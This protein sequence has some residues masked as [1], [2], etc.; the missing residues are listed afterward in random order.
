MRELQKG[1]VTYLVEGHHLSSIHLFRLVQRYKIDLFWGQSF[2]GKGALD[3]V[4]IMGSYCD[5]CPLT[6]QILVEFVLQRYERVVSLF[7]E[8]EIS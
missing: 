2:V 3:L 6:S 5:E 4:E 7:C 1:E 8:L